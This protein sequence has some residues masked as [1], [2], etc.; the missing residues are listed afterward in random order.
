MTQAT[1]DA[2]RAET[3]DLKVIDAVGTSK[4]VASF[5]KWIES[6]IETFEANKQR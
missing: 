4:D 6:V 1:V 3:K 5:S 2:A